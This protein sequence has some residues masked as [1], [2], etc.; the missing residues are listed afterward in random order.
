M[1]ENGD[2]KQNMLESFK[3]S[4]T[5]GTF[6]TKVEYKSNFL[7]TPSEEPKLNH[8][9]NITLN[10]P[11]IQFELSNRCIKKKYVQIHLLSHNLIVGNEICYFYNNKKKK[12]S[13]GAKKRFTQKL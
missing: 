4:P 6:I 13:E 5:N 9:V 3:L 11:L 2:L 7:T 8:W 10:Q 1:F 12:S